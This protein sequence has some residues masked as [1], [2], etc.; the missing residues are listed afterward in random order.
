MALLCDTGIQPT[1][2]G[3]RPVNER[4]RN[5][6][7][8]C[9]DCA[10]PRYEPLQLDKYYKVVSQSFIGNGGDGFSVSAANLCILLNYHQCI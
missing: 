10:V 3:S 8:R 4:V 6:T 5:V 7:V 9:I 2:D 1:I